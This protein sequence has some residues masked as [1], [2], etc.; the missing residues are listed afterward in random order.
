MALWTGDLW[1]PLLVVAMCSAG[2]LAGVVTGLL[3]ILAMLLRDRAVDG[4]EG[5]GQ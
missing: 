1:W 5:A 4:G 2:V 3:L